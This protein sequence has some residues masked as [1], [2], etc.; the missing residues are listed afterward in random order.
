M[1]FSRSI[2]T[3]AEL[4]IAASKSGASV[5]RY[6][7]RSLKSAAAGYSLLRSRRL[8]FGFPLDIF[9]PMAKDTDQYSERETQKRM[10]DA[11]RRALTTP[12]KP[13]SELKAK[14]A[15]SP[16]RPGRAKTKSA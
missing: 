6:A 12:H 7:R 1:R 15:K 13:H 5:N 14:K 3:D 8:G 4:E 9:A 16:K 10:D 2:S 11:L